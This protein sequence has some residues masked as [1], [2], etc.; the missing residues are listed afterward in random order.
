MTPMGRRGQGRNL[1][2][3]ALGEFNLASAWRVGSSKSNPKDSSPAAAALFAPLKAC[4][5]SVTKVVHVGMCM[6][7]V[8]AKMSV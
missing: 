7:F 5:R 3:V 2:T 6:H 4:R 8:I 1:A